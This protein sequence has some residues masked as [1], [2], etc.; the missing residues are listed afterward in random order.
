MKVLLV[1]PGYRGH[2]RGLPLGL[3]Y[4]GAALESDSIDVRVIDM[5][6]ESIGPINLAAVLE[7]Y[8]PD[9][10][11][12]TA[13]CANY[14]DAIDV[15]SV[16]RQILGRSTKIVMGGPHVTFGAGTVLSHHDV[17]FCVL[18][19]GD[20]TFVSLLRQ[21]DSREKRFQEVAGIAI[22]VN[23][24]PLYTRPQSIITNLNLL[25][26]PARHLFDL[27]KYP[28]TIRPLV[29][30]A[31]KNTEL[32]ASRG[33]PYSCEFCSTK[34]FW[35][36][37]YRRR[38]SYSVAAELNYLTSLGYTDFY[39]DDDTFAQDR[40]WV[41]NLCDFVIKNGLHIRWACGCRVDQIDMMLL[42]KMK[43]AGCRYIYFGVESSSE[44][45]LCMQQ[46]KVSIRQV[47][48]AFDLMKEAG[49]YSSAALIFGLP[50]E[51]WE[52][53]KQTV[54][55]VRDRLNP[56]MVWISKACCYPGTR[57]ALKYG[58]TAEDYELRSEGR[59]SKG[60]LYG[61]GGIYTPFFNNAEL[62]V[63]IWEYIYAELGHIDLGFADE[64][65]PY[66]PGNI[67]KTAL[68]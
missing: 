57:M 52:T 38:S 54:N 66:F 68:A 28:S 31:S 62:V 58:I 19:E 39:F 34:E 29:Q 50:G 11:G 35:G 23:G 14:L 4:L 60:L 15:V 6:A 46:K 26:M 1:S 61:L 24:K 5:A 9:V 27:S 47:E 49:I 63:R 64:L 8:R 43:Q 42:L 12:I 22:N 33:C 65:D 67:Y 36:R 41:K 7:E 44:A 40:E 59:S 20:I 32:I 51:D 21:I 18:G 3:A 55:W 17:D 48:S 30:N 56:N 25:P 2:N 53:A 13:V 10:V 45:I 37:K 16:T